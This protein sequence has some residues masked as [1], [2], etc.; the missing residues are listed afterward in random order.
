MECISHPFIKFSINKRTICWI[1]QSNPLN[2]QLW[3][4]QHYLALDLKKKGEFLTCLDKVHK[5][6]IEIYL[7]QASKHPH[8][9]T[10]D[11]CSY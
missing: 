4:T 3:E 8:E 5:E 1:V 11:A 2:L 9:G 10:N 7:A 6:N